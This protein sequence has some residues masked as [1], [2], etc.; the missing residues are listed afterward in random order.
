MR[1]EELVQAITARPFRSLR[2]YLS[3]G[4]RF[5]IRHPEMLMVTRHSAIVG[6]AENGGQ[7]PSSGYPAMERHTVVDLLHIT[8][9][10]QLSPSESR[11]DSA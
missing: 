7:Q 8:R 2:L 3:D 9:F 10:E 1:R 11:N 5:D 4:G 6:L